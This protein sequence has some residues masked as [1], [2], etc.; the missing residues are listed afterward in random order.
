MRRLRKGRLPAALLA[1]GLLAGCGGMSAPS[2]GLPGDSVAPPPNTKMGQI[3]DGDYIVASGDTLATVSSRT[4]TPIRA[5][6]DNNALQP[7]YILK[8]GQRLQIAQRQA[9]VVQAGDTLS[10]IAQRFNVSQSALVDLN[11]LVPPYVIR[12]GQSLVLPSTIEA[13]QQTM[14]AQ[15]PI[16]SAPAGEI[17]AAPLGSTSAPLPASGAVAGGAAAQPGAKPFQPSGTVNATLP[18]AGATTGPSTSQSTVVPLEPDL[19]AA[20]EAAERAYE[21]SRNQAAA[22]GAPAP[23]AQPAPATA[24]TQ[25]A[26]ATVGPPS[27]AGFSWPVQGKVIARFGTTSDGLRNDGINIAAPAGAPV[28]AAADGTVAYAGNQLRGFGNLILLRHEN[29]LITAY[30]HNQSM[31]VEKGAKVKR[32]DVIARVGSTGSVD[33]PQLH[34]EIR[35]GEQAV[36]PLKYLDGGV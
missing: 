12:I 19:T 6:I 33:S 26:A 30:A 34:F 17:T 18:A 4:N 16:E 35:K 27:K 1:C 10:G 25:T 11:D 31:L 29:G 36:D 24:P 7:P 13:P 14:V 20:E 2:L 9:Y 15:Q 22:T 3:V 23:V 28:M 5:L 8:P 21:E 32:G